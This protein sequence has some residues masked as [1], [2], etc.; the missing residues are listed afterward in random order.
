[1]DVKSIDVNQSLT[2]QPF[3]HRLKLSVLQKK[4]LKS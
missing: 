4:K 1:M 2:D 3:K